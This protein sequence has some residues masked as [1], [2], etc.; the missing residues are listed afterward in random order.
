MIELI[1]VI[2]VVGILAKFGTDIYL[3]MYDSYVKSTYINELQTKNAAAVQSLANRLRYRIKDSLS[4][5]TMNGTNSAT[6]KGLDVDTWND[7][8]WS[9]IIDLNN[10]ATTATSLVS[11]AT[12]A[13]GNREL[14]FIGS[15]VD[16]SANQYYNVTVGSNSISGNFAG[17]DVYEYYQL[18]DA[19][20]TVS[21]S[22]TNLILTKNGTNYTLT[23]DVQSFNIWKEGDGLG[24]ELCQAKAGSTLV[25]GGVCK[26]MFIF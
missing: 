9:G 11:P 21:V 18:I 22:G 5:A 2:V 6:W 19:T 16:N 15:N 24:I 20:Y 12:T 10:A 26:K 3:Q 7:G 17:A 1:F 8:L 14:F 23:D 25:Q 4:T 13:V